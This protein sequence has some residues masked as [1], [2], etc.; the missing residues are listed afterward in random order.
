MLGDTTVE[1][2][3]IR[4]IQG[5]DLETKELVLISK[6]KVLINRLH[7]FAVNEPSAEE[8]MEAFFYT[9][10]SGELYGVGSMFHLI[11]GFFAKDNL[12]V[13]AVKGNVMEPLPDNAGRLIINQA[14]APERF[15]IDYKPDIYE[16]QQSSLPQSANRQC[17]CRTYATGK[18]TMC[19]IKRSP[20]ASVPTALNGSF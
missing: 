6:G 2:A 20:F 1:D 4:G 14:N 15:V 19:S 11:G 12:T 18:L 8:T 10:S 9:D 13:H 5:N 7:A 16:N 3:N 17:K